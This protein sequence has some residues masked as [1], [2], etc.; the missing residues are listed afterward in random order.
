MRWKSLATREVTPG[1]DL[2]ESRQ[3]SR[4]RGNPRNVPRLPNTDASDEASLVFTDPPFNVKIEAMPPATA[5]FAIEN[6]PCRR[7][8]EV[9]RKFTDLSGDSIHH[10]ARDERR[11]VRSICFFFFSFCAGTLASQMEVLAAGGGAFCLSLITSESGP[12]NAGWGRYNRAS[13]RWIFG[14]QG[15]GPENIVTTLSSDAMPASL[16]IWQ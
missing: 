16:N 7:P 11:M 6:S 3:A 15:M 2:L 13:T 4:V 5:A 1:R 8:N 12:R 14:F 10:M 9:R